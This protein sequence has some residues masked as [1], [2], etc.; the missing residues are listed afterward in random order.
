[1]LRVTNTGNVAGVI[2][3]SHSGPSTWTVSYSAN[4]LSLGP[5]IGTDIVVSVT[6]PLAA[7]PLSTG[8]VTVTAISQGDTTASDAAVLRTKVS[9]ELLHLPA[10]LRGFR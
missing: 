1:M 2:G 9:W 3:L 6:I 5:G 10:I 4:P 8:V 7:P